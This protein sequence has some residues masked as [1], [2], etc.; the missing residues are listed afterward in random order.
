MATVFARSNAAAIL[1]I[2]SCNFAWLLFES[3]YYFRA[4]FIKLRGIGEVVCKIKELRRM[5]LFWK[6]VSPLFLL[7]PTTVAK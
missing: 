1:F 7:S 3:S 5:K 2:S 4:V 6:T